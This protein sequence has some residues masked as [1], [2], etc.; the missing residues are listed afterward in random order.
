MA[1]TEAIRRALEDDPK[2][3]DPRIYLGRAREAVRETVK[4]NMRAFGSSG[5]ADVT[6]G[7]ADGAGFTSKRPIHVSGGF[8]FVLG[9]AFSLCSHS[10]S[11]PGI[12]GGHVCVDRSGVEQLR[13]RAMCMPGALWHLLGSCEGKDA[14]YSRGTGNRYVQLSAICTNGQ[15]GMGTGIPLSGRSGRG[16]V[17]CVHR[18]V[19]PPLSRP[20]RSPRHEQHFVC[21]DPGAVHRYVC[22]RLSCESMGMAAGFY[23]A[24]AWGLVAAVLVGYWKKTEQWARPCLAD[25]EKN[26]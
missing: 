8:V 9:F 24:G 14:V 21:G 16:N 15:S 26:T 20:G 6:S 12:V 25:V 2:L 1:C 17:G 3:Y 18:P 19:F 5:K 13:A 22:Q 23:V 7:K 10:I 11:L 4:R